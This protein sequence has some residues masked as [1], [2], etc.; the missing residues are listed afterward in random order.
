MQLFFV[1]VLCKHKWKAFSFSISLHT[2]TQAW[3]NHDV[4]YSY[5]LRKL[6]LPFAWTYFSF[7][8]TWRSNLLV[9][10]LS[11]S[12]FLSFC[13]GCANCEYRWESG[14]SWLCRSGIKQTRTTSTSQIHKESIT[15]LCW[16]NVRSTKQPEENV[17][18]DILEVS[19]SPHTV[20]V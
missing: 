13:A 2:K 18:I 15:P 20:P 12:L 11:A 6:N 8:F 1:V 9:W 10:Y 14:I 16:E 17:L 4:N 3:T 5:L 19:I 7:I